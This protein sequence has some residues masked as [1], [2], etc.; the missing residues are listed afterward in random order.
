MTDAAGLLDVPIMF[1]A[2]W[3]GATPIFA[4]FAT[5]VPSSNAIWASGS[6]VLNG[7]Y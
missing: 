1:P 4:Q 2:S 5:V 7:A 3:P 6:L